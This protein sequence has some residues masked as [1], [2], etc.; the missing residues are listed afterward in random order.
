MINFP[1]LTRVRVLDFAMNA[2]T[3]AKPGLD[4]IFVPAVN[5]IIGINGLGKTTLLTMLLRALTGAT[6]VPGNDDLGDRRR[7]IVPAD[8]FW[9]RRRAPD[10]AVNAKV[11]IWFS[12]GDH[13]FEVTRSLANLDVVELS[14][15][16]QPFPTA[17]GN[18]MEATYRDQVVAAS[19]A[20]P[21]SRTSCS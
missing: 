2:G 12:L 11:T 15:D 17:R 20:Y 6:D 8:R 1:V 3:D 9:F 14:V 21:P 18:E 10:D 16:Q 4:H 7:R 5:V 13:E 19:P